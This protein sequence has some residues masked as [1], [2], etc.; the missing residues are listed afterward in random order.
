MPSMKQIKKIFLI[1]LIFLITGCSLTK[2]KLEVDYY[3]YINNEKIENYKLLE[4][5]Y[6]WGTFTEAQE[7]VDSQVSTIIKEMVSTN[8][9]KNITILYNQVLDTQ[10]RNNNGLSTLN[11]YL[12]LIDSSTT[13]K[14]FINSA[15]IIE[16]DLFVPIFTSMSVMSDFKDTSKNIIYLSPV[17][18]DFGA[19]ADYYID[20]DYLAQKALV[21]QYGIKLLKLYG[22]DKTKAREVSKNITDYYTQISKKS[23]ASALFNDVENMYNIITKEELKEIYSNLNSSYFDI[24]PENT[25]ISI[26]DRGNYE[27][28]NAS[29]TEENIT[30]LKESVKLKILQSY[31]Q[32][33]TEDYAKIADNL[34]NEQLGINGET[35]KEDMAENII[36]G[37]FRYDID[38]IYTEKY[39]NN[40]SKEYIETMINDILKYYEKNISNLNW[41]SPKTKEKAINKLKNITVNIGLPTNYPTYSNNYNLSSNKSL[42][43]NIMSIMK[44][45]SDYEYQRLLNNEKS[46][47][48]DQ[49]TVNAYYN[50]QDNSINFPSATINLVDFNKTYYENLGSIGMII[51]HEITHAFDSNGSK[52][53]ENGNLLNWWTEEDNK[54]YKK[55]QDKVIN[56]YN[57]YEVISGNY[58]NGELTV[59]ENIADLGAVACISGIA[60]EKNATTKEF[61]DMYE[62]FASLW[63]E[64]S[65]DEYRKMLLLVDTHSPAKYR[66]NA[67]L[68]STDKFYEVYNISKNNPMYIRKEERLEIW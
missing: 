16:N 62:S 51:A 5:E 39:L 31:C 53:D 10:T 35:T 7:Q 45:M 27:A 34:E 68:A 43:E 46:P 22:Y 61:K 40:K 58:I 13:I 28:I 15:T 41:L 19:P 52:F 33:L 9:N 49:V 24:I 36:S 66:V 20:E 25:K 12:N 56:Y 26:L 11:Y 57:K 4:D 50:P 55:L 6:Y 38:K 21:K 23:K 2:D 60:E 65:T 30:T 1:I 32:Y 29:L 64:K 47:L 14:E 42:I 3:S 37:L 67:T 8:S 54:N 18:F 17:T 59:N 48:M 44:I 63:I